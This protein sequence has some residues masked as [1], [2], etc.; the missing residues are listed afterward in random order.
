MANRSDF[1]EEFQK[2]ISELIAKSPAADIE[3]NV[4]AMMA[5]TFSRLDLITREEFDTQSE[6]LERALARIAV[7]EAKV[8]ALETAASLGGSPQE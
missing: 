4:K 1:F 2:N 6:L 5:Q 8:Q 7:L 3:R